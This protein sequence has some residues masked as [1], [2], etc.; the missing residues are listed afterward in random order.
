MAFLYI[1]N[2]YLEFEINNTMSFTITQRNEIITYKLLKYVQ[3]LYEENQ[4]IPW[5]EIKLN[6]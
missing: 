2:K 1:N 5:K 4:N 3:S 6:K